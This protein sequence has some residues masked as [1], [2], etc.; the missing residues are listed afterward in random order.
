[1]RRMMA[2]DDR[3]GGS[4]QKMAV[5]CTTIAFSAGGWVEVMRINGLSRRPTQPGDPPIDIS[6]EDE[7]DEVEPGPPVVEI[8]DATKPRPLAI[9]D[10]VDEIDSRG[11]YFYGIASSVE[12]IKKELDEVQLA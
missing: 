5:R 10:F 7:A 2:E 12:D 9:K 3:S 6:S 11:G 8:V 4:F 1:M